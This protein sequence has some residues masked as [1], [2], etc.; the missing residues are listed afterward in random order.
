VYANIPLVD[1]RIR[2]ARKY[3][4]FGP[5]WLTVSP[6][7]GESWADGLIEK[8]SD[9]EAIDNGII[10][11]DEVHMWAPSTDWQSIPW[12]FR[13]QL[14]QQRKDGIDI[15]WTAQSSA[16]VFNVIRELTSL[17]YECERYASL[18]KMELKCP[19]TGESYGKKYLSVS[20][21]LIRLYDTRYMVGSGDG[22]VKGRLGKTRKYVDELEARLQ[23]QNRKK[24]PAYAYLRRVELADGTVRYERDAE[25]MAWWFKARMGVVDVEVSPFVRGSPLAGAAGTATGGAE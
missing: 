18:I 6:N 9:L 20:Q 25:L 15:W 10:L 2:D 12:Q 8:M 4:F 17:C 21:D 14:A 1:R 23:E 7:Y 5:Q 22:T 13:Q 11:L 19:L 3:Y 16:R 24:P